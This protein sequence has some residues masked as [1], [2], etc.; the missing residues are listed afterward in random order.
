LKTLWLD[1]NQISD[2]FPIKNLVNLKNLRLWKNQITDISPLRN[3][4]NLEILYLNLNP[5]SQQQIRELKKAL[6][7]CNIG[8]QYST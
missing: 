2:I 5:I 6:P 3:L 7:K 1:E 8:Y 4:V